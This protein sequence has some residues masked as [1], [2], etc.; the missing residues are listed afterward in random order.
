MEQAPGN[1]CRCCHVQSDVVF[2][3]SAVVTSVIVHF[4]R[5]ISFKIEVQ[6]FRGHMVYSVLLGDNPP[7]DKRL[8]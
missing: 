3:V 6:A 8:E 1:L 4:C 5:T 2:V 7:V